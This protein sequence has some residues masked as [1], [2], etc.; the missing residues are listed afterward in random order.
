M[1]AERWRNLERLYHTALER[2]AEERSTFLSEACEGDE[3]LRRELESLLGQDVE[4]KSPLDRPAWEDVSSLLEYARTAHLEPGMQ[5]GPYRIGTAIGAG[6]MGRV[7]KAHD[8]RLGRDVALKVLREDVAEHPRRRSRFEIEARA[9]AALNHPNIVSIFDFG[10]VDGCLYA[11]SELIEGESLRLLLR[12]GPVSVRKLVDIAV[13]I[14]DGLA[15][16]HAARIAHR[17]LKPENVIIT[18]E[19][20]VKILD[21]GL[22][23]REAA[24]SQKPKTDSSAVPVHITEPGTILGTPSY[25]SPEQACGSAVDYRSDQF[26]FGLILYELATGKRAFNKRSTV[27]TLSA[28]VH[29]EPPPIDT[30]YLR[31]FAGSSTVAWPRNRSIVTNQR[32]TYARTFV[33]C[34]IIYR[35]PTAFPRFRDPEE[36][37]ARQRPG[38][39][40]EPYHSLSSF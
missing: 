8:S 28:I 14:A 35:R 31:R 23:H 22:A 17:D 9:V 37:D 39:S 25:M 26:S 7:Y 38:F 6:G 32:T 1:D 33:R 21:F 34:A 15:A 5:V 27:E 24:A 4:A 20:R 19:G 36:A 2:G 16:A 13:Q 3:E 18:G 40:S 10:E 29:E 30:K 12:R 11:V